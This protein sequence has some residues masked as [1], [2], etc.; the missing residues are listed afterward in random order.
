MWPK[1]ITKYSK[2][3]KGVLSHFPVIALTDAHKMVSIVQVQLSKKKK[4]NTPNAASR[5][6]SRY[7]L[8][9]VMSLSALQSIHGRSEPFFF[10]KSSKNDKRMNPEA[11]ASRK[12]Y[13]IASLSGHDRFKKRQLAEK[14]AT[15]SSSIPHSEQRCGGGLL[16]TSPKSWYWTMTLDKIHLPL[17]E[18]SRTT[19]V[20]P[21]FHFVRNTL[22]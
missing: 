14:G 5:R 2:W 22:L 17:R 3:P 18:A 10:L 6:G 20:L 13:S 11:K 12:F 16:K 21:A 8:L 4:K 9:T 19:M 7:L 1:G 15:V